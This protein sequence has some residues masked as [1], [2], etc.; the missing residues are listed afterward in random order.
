GDPG[1]VGDADDQHPRPLDRLLALVERALDLADA[2]ERVGLVDLAGQLDELGR[3]VV[4][5][6]LVSEVEGVDRQAVTT[7]AGAGLE[8]HEPER[9]AG[10]GGEDTPH[11]AGA[12]GG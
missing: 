2:E 11:L 6:S 9:L 12:P 4:L 10:G 5:A 7:H 8:A 1:L 3:E